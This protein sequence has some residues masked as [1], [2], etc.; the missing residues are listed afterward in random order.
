MS[1]ASSTVSA[2]MSVASSS[3]AAG[4]ASAAATS[5]STSAS[6]R[7]EGDNRAVM[8]AVAMIGVMTLA[9]FAV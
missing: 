2:S 5:S 6:G 8:A 7:I 3:A 9:F 4:S 1:A